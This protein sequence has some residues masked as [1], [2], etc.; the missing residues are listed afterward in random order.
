MNMSFFPSRLSG[1]KA[2][3]LLLVFCCLAFA[4]SG[5]TGKLGPKA[6]K[7]PADPNEKQLAYGASLVLANNWNMAA[8]LEPKAMTKAD[9]ESRLQQ[10]PRILMMTAVGTPSARSIQPA[11]NVSLV[12]QEGSFMP[13]DFAERLQPEEY[14]ALSRDLYEREKETAKKNKVQFNIMN[15]DLSRESINGNFAVRHKITVADP[16][17]VPINLLRWDVYLPGATGIVILSECDSEQPGTENEILSMA[18][19][20]RLE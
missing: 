19:S 6:G 12:R 17:G 20:L 7:T 9:L 3:R 1:P 8:L 11:L 2:L 13:R 4:A 18:R 16:S 5:C 15:I 14:K 10:N